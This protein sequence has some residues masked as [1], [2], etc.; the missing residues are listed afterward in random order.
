MA[1]RWSREEIIDQLE[2]RRRQEQ[3]GVDNAAHTEDDI[4]LAKHVYAIKLVD[5]FVALLQLPKHEEGK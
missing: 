3:V 1:Y 5:A 2:S 4:E